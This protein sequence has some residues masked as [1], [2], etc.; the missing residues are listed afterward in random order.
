M[1]EIRENRTGKIWA[2][3]NTVQWSSW[4]GVVI[5]SRILPTVYVRYAP[6]VSWL[7]SISA[8]C[9]RAVFLQRP[10]E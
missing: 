10:I 4:G 3:A 1:L 2:P 7:L 5:W 6:Y 9:Y 8:S